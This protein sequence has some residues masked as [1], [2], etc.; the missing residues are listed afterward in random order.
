MIHLDRI[1]GPFRDNSRIVGLK[2]G[3]VPHT[4]TT[5]KGSRG[6]II[7]DG[8]DLLT[9]WYIVDR[10]RVFGDILKDRAPNFFTCRL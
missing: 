5:Y 4:F 10:E 1:E 8:S 2:S 6:H 7:D 3:P 9:G